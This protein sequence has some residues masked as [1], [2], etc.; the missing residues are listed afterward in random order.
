MTGGAH[1][2]ALIGLGEVGQVLA[3][4]LQRV[5]GVRLCAWDRLFAV[6]DSEPQR[7][8]RALTFLQ[9]AGS[10]AEALRGS[11]VVISAVTAG[12]CC[13]VAAEAAPALTPGAFYLD[14]NSVSPRTR[15]EAAHRI[16]AAG[17]RYVEAA[18]MSPIAPQRIASPIWLG[19][20]HAREFLPLARTLGFARTAAY[21][22][23][24]GRASAAKM[25]RSVIVKGMEAL[26]AEALLTARRHGVEDVVLASLQDLFPV[27]DWRQLARYMISRSLQHGTRRSEEMREAARTVSEAGFEPWMC[28][29][30]VE[31]QRWAA[32][33]PEALGGEELT[34]MLD[35]I[36]AQTPATDEAARR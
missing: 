33:Y 12:E 22:E 30:S 28:R 23:E 2:V 26:L 29:G 19:G 20:A 7:A 16:E 9:A 6:A 24:I 4:D 21:A 13:A 3:H 5:E 25:C 32:R 27:G 35:Q 18:V 34:D 15:A 36:L 31:R 1:H 10:L 8:A 17:G 14:L 11:T